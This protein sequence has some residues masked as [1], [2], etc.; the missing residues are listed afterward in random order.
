MVTTEFGWFEEEEEGYAEKYRGAVDS[1]KIENGVLRRYLTYFAALTRPDNIV[2]IR[3][4]ELEGIISSLVSEGKLIRLNGKTYPNSYLYRSD[5]SDVARSEKN[6]YICTPEREDAGPTNNW[7]NPADALARFRDLARGAYSGKTMYVVPYILGPEESPF[8]E[9]GVEIT[10]NPYVVANMMMITRSGKRA[11]DRI[12]ESTRFVLGVHVTGSLNPEERYIMHLPEDD[13]ILSVNTAYGGNALL[14]KKCHALRIASVHAK[15]DGWMAEHMMAIE[16]VRPDGRAF[17]I[18][19]AFPS[20]SGKTNLSMIM[21]PSD[22]EG[23]KAYLVSDDIAWMHSVNGSLYAIN[24]EYGFFGVAPGTNER[25]NPN[26]LDA[27]RHDTIFTNVALTDSGEPWWE[28]LG[29]RPP[30]LIDWQ[31]RDCNGCEQAAHPNSRF[32]TP[33]LNYRQLSAKYSDPRGLKVDAMLFGGRRSTLVPLVREARNWAQGVLFGAMLRA[34]TTAAITGKVG[35]VRQDPMAMIAFCG[36]NMAD[37]FSH[38]LRMGSMVKD[39]PRIY[40][41]NW[42]RKDSKGEFIWPGFGENMRVI[43]WITGRVSGEITKGIE[44]PI[45]I[46]PEVDDIRAPGVSRERLEEILSVD[47]DGWLRELD[48]VEAFFSQFGDRFPVELRKEIERMREGLEN[49]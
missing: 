24:P 47:R 26:A 31:G 9:T 1:L 19:G 35:V 7:M 42:F 22:M 17:G 49:W 8:A 13:M 46:L 3:G 15:R 39:R 28:G 18:T 38:W 44:T 41:V 34:E 10:D 14:S 30:H 5:P 29:P 45:G 36:Y 32:T 16:V 37:Y 40:Y 33:I 48:E 25:T 4:D 21:P 2:L 6:T 12:G 27:I 43:E 23:W 20:A 11:L